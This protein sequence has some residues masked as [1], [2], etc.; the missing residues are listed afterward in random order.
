MLLSRITVDPDKYQKRDTPFSPA[1]VEAIVGEGIVLSKFDPLPLMPHAD[2]PDLYVVGGDGH[3][4]YEAVCRLRAAGRLPAAWD[5]GRTDSAD[6]RGW[7]RDWDVPD[8][9]VDAAEAR[10]LAWTGNLKGTGFTPCEEARVFQEMLDAPMGIDRVALLTHRTEH[11]IRKS[12]PLLGLCR[13]IRAMVGRSPDAGGVDKFIAQ[14]MAERFGRYGIGPQQ[15]QELWHRVLKHADLSQKFVA[16]LIDQVGKDLAAKSGGPDEGF[17]FQIPAGVE[18]V[19]RAMRGRADNQRRVQRGLAWLMQAD[20]ESNVLAQ[21]FPELKKLLDASGA[22]M[23]DRANRLTEQ[24]AT[25]IGALVT[26]S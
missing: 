20:R 6:A 9:A 22:E 7:D 23:L 5:A 8:K 16:A 2:D 18:H 13:D 12:L 10:M 17:L 14:T 19:M 15:Q 4:R 24:D 21:A 1:T 25:V 3:S 11:Y 26:A